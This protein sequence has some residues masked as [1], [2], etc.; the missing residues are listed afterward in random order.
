ME[1]KKMRKLL[2]GR[3]L[4]LLAVTCLFAMTPLA[5]LAQATPFDEESRAAAV[6]MAQRVGATLSPGISVAASPSDDEAEIIPNVVEEPGAPAPEEE[7]PET[8]PTDEP[9]GEPT[10]LP[11]LNLTDLVEYSSQGV[12]FHAPADWIVETDISES[13]P[14]IIEVPGTNLFVSMES[15]TG[16]DFPSWLAMALFRSQTELLLAEFGADAQLI[17]S[18]TLFNEQNLPIAKVAFTGEDAGDEIGGSL[19][20][21]APNENA[22]TIIG[23]GTVAE[24][25]YAAPGIDLIAESIVFDEDL[26]SVTWVEDEPLLFTDED[27][28]IEVEIPT[29]WYVLATGDSQFPIMV[30]ERDVRYV[31]AVSN[32][33]AFGEEFDESILSFIPEDGELDPEQYDELFDAIMEMVDSSGSPIVVDEE[34]STFVGRD[35]ALTVRLVG[36][37]ELD[38]GLTMPIAFYIDLRTTGV[39]AVVV[40]GDRASAFAVEEEIQ[41]MLESVT[42][43]ETE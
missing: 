15:D 21:V 1:E 26:I 43:L 41:A 28:T 30:A 36:D 8:E 18:T 39:G 32:E 20:V 29:G 17:E 40:F 3:R 27:E 4:P 25:E 16:L 34:L 14:F 31:I 35:G 7:G 38:E 10:G 2:V 12:T 33:S 42:G 6:T 23:G 11:E 24:W 22:Y 9:A 5:V 13:T 37:A 19:F